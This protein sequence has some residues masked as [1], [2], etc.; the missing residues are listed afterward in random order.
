MTKQVKSLLDLGTQT[1]ASPLTITNRVLGLGIRGLP[2][3]PLGANL[4][5]PDP[6]QGGP[7]LLS[8][9]PPPTGSPPG[10]PPSPRTQSAPT[11]SAEQRARRASA[12]LRA[13][14]GGRQRQTLLTSTL[15]SPET[16]GLRKTLLGN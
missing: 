15:G 3:L 4:L 11:P 10:S 6:N 9:T 12:R 2:Q 7:P 16:G 13:T 14:G 5:I 1:L 8:P